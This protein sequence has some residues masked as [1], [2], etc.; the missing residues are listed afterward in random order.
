MQ[1]KAN[2]FNRSNGMTLCSLLKGKEFGLYV[3]SLRGGLGTLCHGLRT[4]YPQM[5]KSGHCTVQLTSRCVQ[6]PFQKLPSLLLIL[7]TG[8]RY[9]SNAGHMTFN[10]GHM[11]YNAG[12][13][14]SNAGH[15]TSNAGHMTSN[16]GHI[17]SNAGHVASNASHMT[18]NAGHMASNAGHMTSN[19][20][21]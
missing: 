9:T 13:V 2:L 15:M 1:V 18:F 12:H 6:F 3:L 10:A 21:T 5:Q 16:A 14:T 8:F 20:V 19:A 11:A 4:S 17:T 7:Q